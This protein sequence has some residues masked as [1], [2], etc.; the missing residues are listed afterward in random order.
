MCIG[1]F[2]GKTTCV[3]ELPIVGCVQRENVWNACCTQ[4]PAG[5]Y[6]LITET[7]IAINMYITSSLIMLKSEDVQN[8]IDIP[9]TEAY[10]IQCI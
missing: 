10:R 1:C 6:I 5:I 7:D 2:D 9:L 8:D 3:L 4:V